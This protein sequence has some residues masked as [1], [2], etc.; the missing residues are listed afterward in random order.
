MPL[1]HAL[2]PSSQNS[3]RRPVDYLRLLSFS[4]RYCACVKRTFL[5]VLRFERDFTNLRVERFVLKRMFKYIR[6][7]AAFRQRARS[8]ELFI[9]DIYRRKL[10]CRALTALVNEVREA[11]YVRRFQM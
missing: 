9:D 11:R 6:N 3:L 1:G 8:D 4:A 5:D 2:I 10:A 7:K